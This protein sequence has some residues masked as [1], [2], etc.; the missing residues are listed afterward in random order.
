LIRCGCRWKI[1][2]GRI[3]VWKEQWLK[4][5]E[6]LGIRSV[7]PLGLEEMMVQDLW[8]PGTRSWDVGL[9]EELFK[10]EEVKAI[11][12]VTC[13]TGGEADSRIW[14]FADRGAYTVKSA[15][16]LYMT[17]IVNRR[18][19]NVVGE[20]QRLW[21]LYIP[22]KLKQFCWRLARGI[23]P[24][25]TT[26][27]RRRRDVP[28]ECGVCSGPAEDDWHLFMHYS[29]SVDC[30]I[31]TDMWHRIQQSTTNIQ[32]FRDWLMMV[33]ANWDDTIFAKWITVMWAIW[34]ERNQRVWTCQSTIA[35]MV[36]NKGLES[37]YE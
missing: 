7:C 5:D 11:L 35:S 9:L 8:I 26:L 28:V 15:Y 34:R 1:R 12:A 6:C 4:R 2:E 25:R 29:A 3:E 10:P 36:V 19:L 20:W 32:V 22:P 17:H 30:W 24:T 16:K 14:H 31:Q 23:L 27:I 37:L 18:G 13:V 33:L 21:G